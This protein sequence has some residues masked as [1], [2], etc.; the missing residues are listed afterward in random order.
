MSASWRQEERE[1]RGEEREGRGEEREGREEEGG[2]GK[3]Y[4]HLLS[5][6][7]EWWLI[8][9]QYGSISLREYG[10]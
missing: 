6:V 5:R 1:G 4:L 9:S 10:S 8:S 7:Y 3:H 2:E